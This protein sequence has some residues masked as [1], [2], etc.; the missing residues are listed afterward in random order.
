VAGVAVFGTWLA[1]NGPRSLSPEIKYR[2][3]PAG[4]VIL[5]TIERLQRSWKE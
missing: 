5:R 2:P 4:T 3:D 1:K